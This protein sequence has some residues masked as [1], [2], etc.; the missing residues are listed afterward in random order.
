MATLSG[1]TPY[2]AINFATFDLLKRN[3]LP[4]PSDPSFVLINLTLGGISGGVAALATYPT[5]VVRRRIQLQGVGKSLVKD[6]PKYNGIVDCVT[7]I[8]KNEGLFKELLS[9]I[10]LLSCY[11]YIFHLCMR[12]LCSHIFLI[13]LFL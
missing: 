4:P 2:I 13:S 9:I 8:V 10:R 6:M 7:V 12:M 11:C 3:Y 5:D 1:I